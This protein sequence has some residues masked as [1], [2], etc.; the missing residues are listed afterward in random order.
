M[1]PGVLS[2][3]TQPRLTEEGLHL[4]VWATSDVAAVRSAYEDPAIQQWHG[5]SMSV[6]EALEWVEHWSGRW[7]AESGAGWAIERAGLFLGQISLRRI[8]LASGSAEL[9]YWVMPAARGAG[10]ATQ[11]LRCL[12]TWALREAGF[13]RLELAHAV[14]NTASCKVAIQ[15]GYALE[16][17]KRRQALHFDGWHDMHL[18][19]QLDMDTVHNPNS[20]P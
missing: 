7:E 8:D 16:G 10:V 20:G 15:S 14:S 13:H 5:R 11:A 19:A 1:L 2:G 12:S 9:S 17:T 3:S 18:H 4:R 6:V